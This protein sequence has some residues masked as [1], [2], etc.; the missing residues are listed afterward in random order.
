MDHKCK[1][2]KALTFTIEGN[3]FK[4]PY[5]LHDLYAVKARIIW[6]W[7]GMFFGPQQTARILLPYDF[8]RLTEKARL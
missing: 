8:D 7:C 3:P 6:I 4:K 1:K 2:C 5:R